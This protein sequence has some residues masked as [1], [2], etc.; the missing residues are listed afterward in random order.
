VAAAFRRL[1]NSKAECYPVC[2]SLLMNRAGLEI[3]GPSS[4]FTAKGFLPVYPLIERLDNCNFS[5]GTVWEGKILEGP[6]FKFDN[7]R[8][9]G[10]QYI[11]EATDLRRISSGYYDFV[12]SSH[13][14]EH[15]AN[16]LGAL[17]E[18]VRVL[19]PGGS[20]VLVVPHKEGTF[21]HRRPVTALEHLIDDFK[22]E[23]GEDDQTHVAEALKL[24]D[25]DRDWGVADLVTFEKRLGD[26]L[27]FR[28][29]HHHVFD[30]SLVVE[31]LHF[32][33]LQ[34]LCVEATWP[35]HI[36]VAAQV[37]ESNATVR[38]ESFRSPIAEWRKKSPFQI[39]RAGHGCQAS[40]SA[41]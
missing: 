16:P 9:P 37:P 2:S 40:S 1:V 15:T 29:L 31:I 10:Q 27:A 12:L 41:A 19:K 36:V 25:L 8:A 39:D 6:T 4:V 30:T 18:W 17:K 34:L 33:N 24:T 20:L 28:C 11:M 38:N 22:N 23:S 21:D 14:I 5:A 3:G 32:L 26:N 13:S 7:N 35:F